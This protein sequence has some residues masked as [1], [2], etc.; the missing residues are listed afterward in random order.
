[1]AI[2]RTDLGSFIT[3][4]VMRNPNLSIPPLED[5][6][7]ANLLIF[8]YLYYTFFL[9]EGKGKG[10][11]KREGKREGKTRRTKGREPRIVV[12]RST[13]AMLSKQVG[14][15]LDSRSSMKN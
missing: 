14:C 8:D 10:K 12:T 13:W 4:L 1:M 11:G 7:F 15:S 9:L 3:E 2:P 5:G 6:L